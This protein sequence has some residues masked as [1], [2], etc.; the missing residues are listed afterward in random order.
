MLIYLL[1][2]SF[3]FLAEGNY[4]QGPTLLNVI[5]NSLWLS[6]YKNDL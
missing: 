4:S 6:K 3:G 1:T 5:R 2:H